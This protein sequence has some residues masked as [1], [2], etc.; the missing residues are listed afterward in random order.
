MARRKAERPAERG[1]RRAKTSAVGAY[2]TALKGGGLSVR[3]TDCPGGYGESALSEGS[4]LKPVERLF[5][6]GQGSLPSRS[7]LEEV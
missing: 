1:T 6:S 5:G 4:A 3:T 2:L 7:L